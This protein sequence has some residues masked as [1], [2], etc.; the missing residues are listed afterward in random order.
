M[1]LG[2][3]GGKMTKAANLLDEAKETVEHR[4]KEYGPPIVNFANI[5]RRWS[6]VLGRDVTANEVVRC[7]LEVKLARLDQDPHHYDTFVDIAGYAACLEEVTVRSEMPAFID[8][9]APLNPGDV[10]W[11]KEMGKPFR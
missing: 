11:T 1:P 2:S 7:M 5:A 8:P 6:M 3:H 9:G 10:M 4:Q